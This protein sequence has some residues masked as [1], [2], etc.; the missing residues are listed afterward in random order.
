MHS[1]HVNPLAVQTTKNINN[2]ML[3]DKVPSSPRLAIKLSRGAHRIVRG[4]AHIMTR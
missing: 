2:A 4:Q 3:N 1:L